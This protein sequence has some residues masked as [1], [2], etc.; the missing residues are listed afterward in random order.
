VQT[1]VSSDSDIGVFF[2]TIGSVYQDMVIRILTEVSES[3]SEEATKKLRDSIHQLGIEIG[4][5]KNKR[6]ALLTDLKDVEKAIESLREAMGI[7]DSASLSMLM[8]LFRAR[9]EEIQSRLGAVVFMDKIQRKSRLHQTLLGIRQ[10]AD[11]ALKLLEI[12]GKI[13][14]GASTEIADA[15]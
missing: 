5:E 13:C 7:N 15:K 8:V 14:A 2:G 6:D 3:G 1:D 4:R 11:A 12:L 9:A 10:R